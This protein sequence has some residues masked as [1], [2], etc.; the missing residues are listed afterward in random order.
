MFGPRW[1]PDGRYIAA[2]TTDS[3]ALMLFDRSNQKWTEL[4]RMGIGYPSWSRDGQYVYFVRFPEKAA[5]LRVRIS[6][7]KLEQIVDLKDFIPTGVF[8]VWLSLDPDDS[9]LMLR[10]A[11]TQDVYSLDCEAAKSAH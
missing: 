7:R 5:V 11:G 2:C 10:D 3:Q 1:S 9:P 6:D 4:V 8:G